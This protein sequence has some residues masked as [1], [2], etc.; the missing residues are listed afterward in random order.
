M[1][2]NIEAFSSIP[3]PSTWLL[4]P[5]K[6]SIMSCLQCV[7]RKTQRPQFVYTL[8]GGTN[9]ARRLHGAT[10]SSFCDSGNVVA[11]ST[12]AMSVS[13]FVRSGLPMKPCATPWARGAS[14]ESTFLVQ[15]EIA[16]H[17]VF[18]ACSKASDNG[19][20]RSRLPEQDTNKYNRSLV[21]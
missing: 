18:A 7:L 14:P 20:R 11:S 13:V 8:K 9:H 15:D 10:Y 16:S 17:W 6:R 3:I 5:T 21:S 1:C 12:L 4:L 19:C 2:W